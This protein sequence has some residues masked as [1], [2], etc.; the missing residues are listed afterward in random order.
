MEDMPEEEGVAFGPF[1]KWLLESILS[2]RESRAAIADRF[3]TGSGRSRHCRR[4]G[5]C[6]VGFVDSEVANRA[7][8]WGRRWP[9]FKRCDGECTPPGTMRYALLPAAPKHQAMANKKGGRC[10]PPNN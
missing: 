5:N 3:E 9:V 2:D 6:P 8:R 10:N 1:G 4:R 7:P